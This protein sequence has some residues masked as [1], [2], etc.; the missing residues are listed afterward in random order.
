MRKLAN[1]TLLLILMTPSTSYELLTRRNLK[2]DHGIRR[3]D[4]VGI[5][6]LIISTPSVVGAFDGGEASKPSF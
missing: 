2:I 1:A 3:R 5:A 6:G 4:L